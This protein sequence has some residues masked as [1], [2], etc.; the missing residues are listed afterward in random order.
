MHGARQFFIRIMNLFRRSRLDRDLSEQLDAHRDMI[1]ADLIG[2]GIE[3]SDAQSAAKRALGNDALVR[4]FSRNEMV[5]R[6]ADTCIRDLRYGLRS[7]ARTPAFTLTVVLTLA[8][9]IG[10]NT[11]IFSIVD[12]LL[13]RPLPF[14]NGEQ[15]VVI[16][17]T[18]LTAPR[19]DV[20]P[21]NWLDWQRES[22]TFES[23]ALWTNRYPST[24]TGQGDP[25]QLKADTVSYEFFPLLGVQPVLGRVFAA[26]DDR[27]GPG[28]VILSHSLWQRKFA[29]DPAIIGKTI[30]LNSTAAEVIGVMPPEFHFLSNDT[31]V[32]RP[33][34]LDRNQPWREIA[35]RFIPY[36]VGR[37]KP[38][39]TYD[40]AKTELETIAGR[41]GQ[42]Y[43]L[44]KNTSV[45]V[46][47]LVRHFCSYSL[48][49]ESC[50]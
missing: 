22:R 33:F 44:N 4:E 32:W 48:R 38:S 39:V 7:L 30:E 47:P 10:A 25:E 19:M 16:H 15:L 50:S 17:E 24:L 35:G 41:L 18:A 23:L 9:G 20:S 14:Q 26:E 31:D 21:A 40:S 49:S 3:T 37:I 34:A 13:L 27:P 2:R 46:I 29:G 36:V 45:K 12:R 5:H 42:L 43:I 6:F 8:L 1:K 28:T 11:A